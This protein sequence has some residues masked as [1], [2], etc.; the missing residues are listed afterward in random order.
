VEDGAKG[1]KALHWVWPV[2]LELLLAV[3]FFL[4]PVL[5]GEKVARRVG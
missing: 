2:S 4:L 5:H 1:K 3:L